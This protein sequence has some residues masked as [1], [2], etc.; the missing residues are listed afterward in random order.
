MSPLRVGVIGLGFVGRAHVD[1]LRRIPGVEVV[2]AAGSGPHITAQAEPLGIAKAYADYRDLIADPEIDA[3]H[4][5]TPNYLHFAINCAALEAGKACF[6]EKPLT[7]TRQEAEELVRL[8]Q[9]RDV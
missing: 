7:A 8:A 4:N 5:C 2:A 1:A 6:A 3:I 9:A